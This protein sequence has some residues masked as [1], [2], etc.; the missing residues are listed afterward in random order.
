[1]P[2]KDGMTKKQIIVFVVVAII[3]F[4]LF[5]FSGD[6]TKEKFEKLNSSNSSVI[7]K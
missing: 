4:G 3:V 6:T 7:K 5:W 1:M 2:V